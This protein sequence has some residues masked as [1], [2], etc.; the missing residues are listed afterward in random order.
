MNRRKKSNPY[1][2]KKR[3]VK[4]YKSKKKLHN[5]SVM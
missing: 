2:E 1:A 3:K 5:R 4:V